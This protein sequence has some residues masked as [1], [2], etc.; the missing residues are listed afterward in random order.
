MRPMHICFLSQE[1]PPETG[2]GGIG[3]YTY[4]MAHGLARAGHRVTVISLA[5]G[6]ET[7]KRVGGVEV[8]RVRP[9]PDWARWKGLWRLNHVWPGFAWSAALRLR[10]V[11]RSCRV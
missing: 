6:P 3:A 1:D 11:H 10:E 2:W 9:R 7:V 5:A 8:H 4:E